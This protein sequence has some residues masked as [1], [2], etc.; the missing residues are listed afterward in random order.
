MQSVRPLVVVLALVLQVAAVLPATAT[1]RSLADVLGPISSTPYEQHSLALKQQAVANLDALDPQG[2]G[3][4]RVEAVAAHLALYAD[5]VRF[6]DAQVGQQAY[7]DDQQ[8][9]AYLLSRLARSGDP[10]APVLSGALVDLLTAGRLTAEAAITDVENILAHLPAST[11]VDATAAERRL[12]IARNAFAQGDAALGRGDAVAASTHHGNAWRHAFEAFVALGLTFGGDADGDGIPDGLELRVGASPLSSDTDGDGLSDLFEVDQALAFSLP[13]VSDTDGD[14]IPDGDEDTDGDGLTAL[15]EQEFGTDPMEPD[16]DRDGVGDGDEVANG[17]DPLRAD[18]DGDGLLDRVEPRA[19]TDP[20]LWDTDGDG[21][22]DGDELLTFDAPAPDGVR[23]ELVGHGDLVSGF[24]ADRVDDDVRASVPA[25]GQIGPAYDFS[26]DPDAADGFL[27]AQLSLPFDPAALGASDPSDLRV[28]LL[29]EELQ[30]WV[31]AGDDQVVDLDANVVTVTVD[32]FSTYAIFDIVNWNQTWTA[33]QNPCRSR[34]GSGGGDI[35]FLD[36][37]FVLDGSGSMSWNDPQGL[38]KTAS[39][40]FVDALLPEDRAAVVDFDSWAKILQGLTTDHEAV[41]RAIDR[42]DARGGTNIARGVSAGNNILKNNGDPDRARM[43]ILLTDGQGFYN[44]QLTL[45]A[46]VNG[47]TIHTIGLGRSVDSGLL[48]SIATET[49]GQYYGVDSADELPEVFRRISEDTGGDPGT[50]K[51]TDEDG[52][53]DCVEIEGA[54]SASTFE[55]YPSDPT[56]PDTDGDGVPDGEEVRPAGATNGIPAG[57]GFYTIYADP[58]DPDTDGDGADDAQEL[59]AG[60]NAWSPDTDRDGLSDGVEMEI[61]SDPFD[62]NTDDDDFDDA[63]EDSHRSDGLDPLLFDEKVSTWSY[64]T[65]FAKGAVFGDTWRSDSLAWLGGNIASGASSVIPVVGWIVGGI[66][67]L[68]DVVGNLFNGDWAGAGFSALGVIPYAGDAGAIA[69]KVGKF[70]ARNTDKVD[71]IA[72]LVAKLDKLPVSARADVLRKALRHGDELKALGFSDEAIVRLAK[73]RYGFD[74][75][76]D[77]MKRAR[78]VDGVAA[79]FFAT[80]KR[81]EDFLEGLLGATRKG[82]DKQVY[83]STRDLGIPFGRRLDVLVN[84]VAHESKVGYVKWSRRIEKQILKDGALLDARRIQGARW[85][86]FPSS[87]S[88][89]LGADPRVLNLLETNR[90]SYTIHLP[91]T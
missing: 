77:G 8:L 38:R 39:K 88:D 43:M 56:D 6:D 25:L 76:V 15:Q 63:Y 65:E 28:V 72:A 22:A 53:N 84:G 73:G 62:R 44:H 17:T 13:G 83:R 46:K 9:A 45:D 1:P 14:G 49:G 81:G 3:P 59:E 68:R 55:R 82:F 60:T 78:H 2:V 61:H 79:D 42:V 18:S 70:A 91:N 11:T 26:L 51:D 27:Q 85:H 74:H 20:T 58:A 35:V 16:T 23:V 89:S 69:G 19:G 37:T 67:D 41:K 80:G 90:I 66:A 12:R 71:E 4:A 34:D 75:I 52:L 29:D 87:A 54:Q 21:I 33:Q 50:D 5:P 32:H 64:A 7:L 57:A 31:P 10:D 47:I 48:R 30:A 36:L 86:F 24:L 40:N